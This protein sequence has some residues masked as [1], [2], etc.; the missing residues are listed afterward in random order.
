MA[1]ILAAQRGSAKEVIK[2]F[3]AYGEYVAANRSRFPPSAYALATS[4]WYYDPRDHRCPHDAWLEEVRIEE[5]AAGE[6]LEQRTVAV[7]VRL[8][9]AYHDGQIELHYPRVYRYQLELSEGAGG[10]GDWRYDEFRLTDE[11]HLIHEIE[12][13]SDRDAG[14][15]VIEASDVVFVWRPC[16]AS[17]RAPAV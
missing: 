11:G 1:F 3:R 6:R 13:A 8:L 7:R 14:R 15:W 12:W 17:D 2:N 9:G 16:R 4:E 10:H 5:P